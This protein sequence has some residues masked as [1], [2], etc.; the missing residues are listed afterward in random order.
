M[1]GV[2]SKWNLTAVGNLEIHCYSILDRI[3]YLE[4]IDCPR[5]LDD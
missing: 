5:G 4:E 3:N 2:I 1:W